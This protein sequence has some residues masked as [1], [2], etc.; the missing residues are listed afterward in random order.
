MFLGFALSSTPSSYHRGRGVGA[1]GVDEGVPDL[2]LA[3]DKIWSVVTSAELGRGSRSS[4]Y[5]YRG[6]P[7]AIS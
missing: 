5:H 6:G 3:R 2:A 7:S 4:L 1:A